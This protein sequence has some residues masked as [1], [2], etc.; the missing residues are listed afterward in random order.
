MTDYE[1]YAAQVALVKEECKDA[2]NNEIAE[3]FGRNT[4]KSY[5]KLKRF[6]IESFN[7][8]ENFDKKGSITNWE[9]NNTLD[10]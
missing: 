4:I 1:K 10:C 7:Q 5:I 2:D 8:K 6:E 3:A 9:K